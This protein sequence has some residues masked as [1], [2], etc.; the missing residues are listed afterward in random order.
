MM[1][2]KRMPELELLKKFYPEAKSV[3]WPQ[4]ETVWKYL[5]SKCSSLTAHDE[6]APKG[7]G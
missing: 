3:T 1:L 6:W 4:R 2:A 7:E 5:K